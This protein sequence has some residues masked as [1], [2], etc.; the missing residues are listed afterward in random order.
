MPEKLRNEKVL[1]VEPLEWAQIMPRFNCS[2]QS[3]S[4]LLHFVKSNVRYPSVARS[5]GVEGV[6]YVGFVVSKDGV[7]KK[8]QAKNKIGGGCT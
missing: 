8:M 2:S 1:P 3:Y 5:R 7:I 6:V 4:A